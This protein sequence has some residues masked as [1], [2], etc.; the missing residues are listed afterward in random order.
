[1]TPQ[2]FDHAQ[3]RTVQRQPKDLD[4]IPVRLEPLQH[5]FGLMKR[6]VIADQTNLSASIS[7]Y[8]RYQKCKK[9]LAAFSLGCRVGDPTAVVVYPTID[10]QLFILAGG[11]NLRLLTDDCP[12]WVSTSIANQILVLLTLV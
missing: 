5:S 12:H 9:V 2:P 4:L 10:Y 8:Q 1:M 11:G 7:G 6:P 3:V